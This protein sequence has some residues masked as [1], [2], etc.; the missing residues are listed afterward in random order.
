MSPPV[1]P[2]FEADRVVDVGAVVV[3]VAHAAVGDLAVLGP[4]W[5]HQPAGVA[6]AVWTRASKK[7]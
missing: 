1:V 3:E 7:F 6:Q 2:V 4:R 5:L